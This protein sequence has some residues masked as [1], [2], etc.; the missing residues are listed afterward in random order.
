MTPQECG[1]RTDVRSAA[2]LC[3]DGSGMLFESEQ[4]MDVS[5]LPYTAHELENAR[6]PF[7]LPGAVKT[8][9]RC[10][11]GQMGIGGDD[12]W[13]AKPHEQYL[14]RLVPGTPFRFSFCGVRRR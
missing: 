3:A 1:N 12:S 10:S 9:V 6:H 7:E 11:C 2:V 14:C 5:V 4:G 8:V 13:G